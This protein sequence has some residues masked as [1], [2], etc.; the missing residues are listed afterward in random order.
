MTVV[1]L[2]TQTSCSFCEQAKETLAQLSQE[3]DF[4]TEEI[5]LQTEEGR[6]LGERHGVLFA[7]GILVDGEFFSFGRLS[8]RKLRRELQRRNDVSHDHRGT[9]WGWRRSGS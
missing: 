1:T 4:E 7:P 6:A 3:Q 5:S 2:L 9:S 8:E